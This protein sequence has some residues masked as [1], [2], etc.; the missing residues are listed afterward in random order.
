[1]LVKSARGFSDASREPPRSSYRRS[2]AMARRSAILLGGTAV[3]TLSM[4][5]PA[6]AIT[7]NDDQIANR[8][9]QHRS[10]DHVIRFALIG[11]A[12][13]FRALPLFSLDY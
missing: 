12:L 13:L 8:S 6:R 10:A 11:S 5:Q 7:I 3:L 2:G 4:S 9:R 1:M